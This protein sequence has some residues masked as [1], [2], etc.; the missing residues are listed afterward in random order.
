[1]R[2]ALRR[3]ASPSH[4]VWL[5]DIAATGDWPTLAIT[6]VDEAGE[7]VVR[8]QVD[9]VLPRKYTVGGL[10]AEGTDVAMETL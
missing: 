8:W 3:I 5:R 7:A 1:M 9:N 6:L 2:N 10:N 4:L